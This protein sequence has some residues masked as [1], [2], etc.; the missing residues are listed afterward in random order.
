MFLTGKLISVIMGTYNGETVISKAIESILNQTYEN[1]ELIICD[2]CSVDA[3]IKVIEKYMEKDNRI[4]LLRN[5]KNVGLAKSLNNCI[6]IAKGEYVA[7]MDDDDLSHNDRLKKQFEF[8]ESHP[9]YALCGTG[10]HNF[11]RNGIW[12]TTLLK[13]FP[14]VQDIYKGKSF[15]HPTVMMRKDVLNK[16][17]YYTVSHYNIRGQDYDLWCKFY[18]SGYR[19]VNM[20]VILLDYCES[21]ESVKRRKFK[22]RWAGY[23]KRLYWRRKLKLP[24]FYIV[25]A[26]KELLAGI[27]PNSWLFRYKKNECVKNNE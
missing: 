18:F 24:F 21:L 4:I 25:Y 2:D 3:T 20:Q 8:M 19:G 13:K 12:A 7:R 6:K 27:I 22:Y 15:I 23:K 26:Y 5:K 1:F 16:I 17:G 9:E 10:K 14:T 11:D